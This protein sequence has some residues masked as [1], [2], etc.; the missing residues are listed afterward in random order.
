MEPAGFEFPSD[1]LFNELLMKFIYVGGGGLCMSKWQV[2]SQ[3]FIGTHPCWSWC[4]FSFQVVS[5][6]TNVW[7]NP[8]ILGAVGFYPPSVQLSKAVLREPTHVWAVGCWFSKLPFAQ[9]IQREIYQCCSRWVLSFQVTIC[10]PNSPWIL[11][12]LEPV[13][14]E[15][16]SGLLL[17]ISLVKPIN[18]GAGGFRVSIRSFL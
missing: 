4:V 18:V 10:L 12:I 2:I 7:R 13:V 15:F 8:C 14:S 11:S 16:P 17:N 5:C 6:W 1:Y 3:I 9:Q